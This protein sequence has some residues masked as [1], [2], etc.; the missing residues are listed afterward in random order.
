MSKRLNFIDVF[1]G[2]GGLSC[3]LELAGH[4]CLLGVDKDKDSIKTFLKNHQYA[5]AFEG[6]IEDLGSEVLKRLTG[7]QTIH[8]VVGGPPCQG[9]ST[10]G[11]GDPL[12]SRNKL[13]LEFV[14][15]VKEIKP[16]F[17]VVEN[18]TGLLAKK[19]EKILKAI[20]GHFEKLGYHMDVQVVS[21]SH[22]GV[23]ERRRRTIILGT[24]I[25]SQP[26]FPPVT[27]DAVVGNTRMAPV[28]VGDV[29]D[30]LKSK[31]GS[32][33]NHDIEK[34]QIFDSFEKTIISHIPEGKGIRYQQDESS[35]LP[36]NLSLDIDWKNLPEN[37]LRQTKYQR[38]DRKSPSPTIMTQRH[39]YYHP[40]EDRYLTQREAA[41]IQSFP[42]DFEFVGSLTSQWKQIGN[43]VPPLLGQ[44][45]GKSLTKMYQAAQ[46]EQKDQSPS[47]HL[48]KVRAEKKIHKIRGNAFV[49]KENPESC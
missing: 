23:A 40:L 22:Y 38:L 42:H 20:L 32:L 13:F 11:K 49:Y 5:Q 21:A 48:K 6:N 12:D 25:N 30:S 10:V 37:R 1:C 19:N 29:F 24:R 44:A 26:L 3:G 35:Y 4:R 34:S 15:I 46:K 9:F 39:S 31:K 36:S 16:Y 14:R 47:S 28:T 41:A 27:H 7:D 18:V 45:I 17:V 43:A 2:A 33:L 8:A